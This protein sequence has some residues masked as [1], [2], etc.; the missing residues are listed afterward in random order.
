MWW[1]PVFLLDVGSTT[2]PLPFEFWEPLTPR[3][4]FFKCYVE[5]LKF[6]LRGNPTFQQAGNKFILSTPWKISFLEFICGFGGRC[7]YSLSLMHRSLL[8]V[9]STD[10]LHFICIQNLRHI[11]L[12]TLWISEP[13]IIACIH[14]GHWQYVSLQWK[15]MESFRIRNELKHKV[16]EFGP[17]KAFPPSLY[18]LV[19]TSGCQALP[20]VP[21]PLVSYR[22][23]VV[24]QPLC[25]SS[26]RRYR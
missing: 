25:E 16:T 8:S 24:A 2:S 20:G 6:Y 13:P 4:S 7:S 17:L 21:S 15:F 26:E 9:V 22:C 10:L 5:M 3:S 11:F 12:S 19:S 18:V 14:W 23:A 1:Q